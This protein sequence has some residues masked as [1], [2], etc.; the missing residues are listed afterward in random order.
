M[1]IKII[2]PN[3]SE[4]VFECEGVTVTSVPGEEDTFAFFDVSPVAGNIRRSFCVEK[5]TSSVYLM[6]NTGQTIESY[7]PYRWPDTKKKERKKETSE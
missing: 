3:V 1:F 4:E 7:R 2:R 6:S 5:A